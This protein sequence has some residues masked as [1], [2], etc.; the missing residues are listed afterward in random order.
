MAHTILS[1]TTVAHVAL[2]HAIVA[3]AIL[4]PTTLTHVGLTHARASDRF[5]CALAR[6]MKTESALNGIDA[7]WW[8]CLCV[9]TQTL[10]RHRLV[11]G[12]IRN[13]RCLALQLIRTCLR[14]GFVGSYQVHRNS[15]DRYRQDQRHNTHNKGPFPHLNLLGRY[16]LPSNHTDLR[17]S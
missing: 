15:D 8:T 1:H 4:A 7:V 13:I 11:R 10:A 17:R 16:A 3:Q 6:G 5:R 12:R 9:N 14:Y 2:T